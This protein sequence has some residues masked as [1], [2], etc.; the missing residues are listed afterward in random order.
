MSPGVPGPPF[1]VYQYP[2]A[3]PMVVMAGNFGASGV[4]TLDLDP[5]SIGDGPY[6]IEVTEE[7]D[8]STYE[9]EDAKVGVL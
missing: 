9:D 2:S 3:H 7:D 1:D 4:V 5:T 6:T 8:D